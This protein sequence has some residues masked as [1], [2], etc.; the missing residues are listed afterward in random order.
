M[1]VE[2]YRL[3]CTCNFLY[4]R[5]P[6]SDITTNNNLK[7]YRWILRSCHE[8]MIIVNSNDFSHSGDYAHEFQLSRYNNLWFYKSETMVAQISSW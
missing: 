3:V 4:D 1:Q 8:R 7:K 2:I 6:S 5:V